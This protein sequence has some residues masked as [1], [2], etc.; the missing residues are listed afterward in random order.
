M[1]RSATDPLDPGPAGFAH[2]GLHSGDD[3]PENCLSAFAAAIAAGAGIECDLRLT[4]DDRIVVFHDSDALRLCADPAVI[5][6]SS[7]A[8]LGALRVGGAPLPTLEGLLRLVRGQV[9][10]L[11][12][13]KVER[14]LW[15]WPPALASALAGYHGRFGVMSFEPRLIRLVKNKLPGWRRGLVVGDK[16]GPVRRAIAL[17]LAEPDFLAVQRGTAQRGWVARERRRKPVYAWTVRT[18]E[19]RRTLSDQVDALIWEGDG[20]P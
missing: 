1:S 9:P 6:R 8:E 20:R 17:R 3:P 5:G 11:L 10:L 14:D 15:R 19:Q 13:V 18:A 4:R 7:L 12:E 2:R 16:L